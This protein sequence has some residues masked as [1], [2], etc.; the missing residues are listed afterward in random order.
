MTDKMK[1]IMTELPVWQASLRTGATFNIEAL[2]KERVR[3]MEVWF[4]DHV[5]KHMVPG[6]EVNPFVAKHLSDLEDV[7]KLATKVFPTDD[8]LKIALTDLRGSASIVDDAK[9][10]EAWEVAAAEF[11]KHLTKFSQKG[12]KVGESE[13]EKILEAAK[14][15]SMLSAFQSKEF[16]EI[17]NVLVRF[18]MSW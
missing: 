9:R 4:R 16:D 17:F 18:S 11:K 14:T 13:V 6:E 2:C 3:A 15:A 12:E 5:Q 8:A 10:R 7:L 1:H